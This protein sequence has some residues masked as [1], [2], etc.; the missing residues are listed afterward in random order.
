[1]EKTYQ[2]EL[3][4]Y[5]HIDRPWLKYYSEEAINAPLPEG[6]LYDYMISCNAARLDCTALKY[7]GRKITHR[8][9]LHQIQK[10]AAALTARGVKK[11]DM[12][13]VCMLTMPE[14]LVLL[15]AINYVGAVCNFLVLNATEQ[16]LHKQLTLTE[17]QLVFTVDIAAEK[18]KN[19]AQGTAVTEIVI[20]SI[21]ASMPVMTA[22]IVW[23][24]SR[25]RPVHKELTVWKQFLKDGRGVKPIR[26]AVGSQDE[27]VLEYT[28]GTTGESKGVLLSNQAVNTVPFHYKN[29]STVFEFHSGEKFLCIIPPFLSVGLIT[30]LLMPLCLGFELILDPDPDPAKTAKKVIKFRPNHFC[31]GALH[32]SDLIDNPLVE[33]VN[34]SFLSTVAYGGDKNDSQ[35]EQRATQFFFTHGMKHE[36]VNGYGLTEAASSCCTTT[37]NTNFLIP[38]F[39]NNILIRDVDTGEALHCGEEGEI[40]FNG[41]GLMQGYYKNPEA[42]AN[43][44]FE[45]NGVRWMRTG[46]LGMV[47]EDGAFLVTGRLKRIAWAMDDGGLIFRIY[48]M[49]IE[50]I[51]C[52]CPG[53]ARCG[54][55]GLPDSQRGYLPVAFVVPQGKDVDRDTLR[56][57]ILA[58]TRRELNSVSQ[59]HA[60]HFV[61]GLPTTSA[62]KIDF[63]AL[64]Q[65]AEE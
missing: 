12:V 56:R 63:K 40:C 50:E 48:P 33:K 47:T 37:H 49:R 55:V 28:S 27:A 11:G 54:V 15:Y 5:P 4:G 30:T 25:K 1:M 16:E 51:V 43:L 59:L 3:T 62:G 19:A 36:L 26:A 39:K 2:Q 52:Q 32:V 24:K 8:E 23:W 42:T 34:L 29:S 10:C 61:D 41:P 13:S 65:M 21:S 57:D 38:F 60:I 17:S 18:I 45:H 9:F 44:M 7:F 35:W 20:V 53:V 14:A 22:A 58:F 46:D 6:S 31:G 64:E